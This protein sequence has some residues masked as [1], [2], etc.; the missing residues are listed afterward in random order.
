MSSDIFIAS[1]RACTDDQKK[2]VSC[3]LSHLE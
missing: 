2:I 3:E 1:G